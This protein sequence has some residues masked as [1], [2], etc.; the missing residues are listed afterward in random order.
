MKPTVSIPPLDTPITLLG[1]PHDG[2]TMFTTPHTLEVLLP[3]G[4]CYTYNPWESTPLKLVFTYQKGGRS[5][6]EP[7]ASSQ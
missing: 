6:G 1:G 7:V 5:S 3:D 4:E 2:G